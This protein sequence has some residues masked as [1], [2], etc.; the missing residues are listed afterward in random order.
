MNNIEQSSNKVSLWRLILPLCLQIA[1]ILAVPARAFITSITGQT[2]ILKTRPVDPYDLL[3]GY[4]Q[5]LNYNISRTSDLEKLDGWEQVLAE[6]NNEQNNS[7]KKSN[8]LKQ[9][10]KL[11]IILEAPKSNENKPPLP[12]KAIAISLKN[13][14]NLPENQIALQGIAMNTVIKYGLE[15]YYFPEA[16]RNEINN[17]I[18]RN[19]RDTEQSFV[20]EIKVDKTGNALPISLWLGT[21]NYKF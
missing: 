20:V 21:E 10:T 8:Y 5:T 4:S 13:P 6:V 18:N 16:Q 11:Y 17:R 15:R 19:Q 14:Q 3:R 1:F 7:S 9:K 2:I 12:W